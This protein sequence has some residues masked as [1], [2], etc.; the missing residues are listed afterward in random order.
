[1][2]AYRLT[3]DERGWHISQGVSKFWIASG[4]PYSVSRVAP[5]LHASP[6]GAR[7]SAECDH[8]GEELLGVHLQR[9]I[10]DGRPAPCG[11]LGYLHSP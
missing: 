5:A 11:L 7:P 9:G 10:Q 6:Y 3:I 2:P 8:P 1:M 4:S